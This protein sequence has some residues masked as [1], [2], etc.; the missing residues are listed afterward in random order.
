[1]NNGHCD[2]DDEDG[3]PESPEPGEARCHW[4]GEPDDFDCVIAFWLRAERPCAQTHIECEGC[5]YYQ[6]GE[7]KPS[8]TDNRVR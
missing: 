5:Q 1:M 3:N 6:G 2:V 8:S 7:I 4:A